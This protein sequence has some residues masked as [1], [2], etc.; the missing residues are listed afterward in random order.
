MGVHVNPVLGAA[1]RDRYIRFMIESGAAD[2]F[3]MAEGIS[4]E[5][6]MRCPSMFS[7]S[8]EGHEDETLLIDDGGRD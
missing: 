2:V 6:V 8:M 1:A 7:E 4:N 3:N 5:M